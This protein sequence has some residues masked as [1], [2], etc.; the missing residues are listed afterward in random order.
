M[1]NLFVAGRPGGA[2][3]MPDSGG[4]IQWDGLLAGIGYHV[5]STT[6]LLQTSWT[7]VETLIATGA[8]HATVITNTSQSIESLRIRLN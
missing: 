4:V 8:L 3:I 1:D 6:N 2:A 5:Q 7:S